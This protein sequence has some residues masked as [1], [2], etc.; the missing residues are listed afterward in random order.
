MKRR[1]LG[2]DFRQRG[3]KAGLAGPFDAGFGL[4]NALRFALIDEV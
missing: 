4:Y 1:F 3:N 2:R